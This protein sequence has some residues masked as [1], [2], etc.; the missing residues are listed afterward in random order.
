MR[1]GI[2]Q[3]DMGFEEKEKAMA[4]CHQTVLEAKAAEVDFLIF[5]EM[6]LTG[7]TM[8]P[9]T[10]GETEENSPTIAFFR[11]EATTYDM[12]IGFGMAVAKEPSAENHCIIID[13]KG[14]IIADYAKIH[15]F[16]LGTETQHYSGGCHMTSCKVCGVPVTPFICYDLRFPEVFQAASKESKLITVIANWPTPRRAHWITLLQARAIEN[17]CFIVGVNRTGKGGGLHYC[18]DSMVISP[19]GEVLARVASGSGF[20]TVDIDVSEADR[21]RKEFPLKSD[22]K[23]NFYQRLYAPKNI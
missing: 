8:S 13:P 1:I 21:Y 2:G 18:G 14:N 20:T 3:I 16:S 15:P 10:Q 4:V 9:E 23:P 19:Y 22:R 6:T 7:F 5:P 12:T 17:Q 11:Q